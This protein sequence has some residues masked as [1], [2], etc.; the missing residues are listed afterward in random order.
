MWQKRCCCAFFSEWSLEGLF[1]FFFLEADKGGGKKLFEF[2]R[3][4]NRRTKPEALQLPRPYWRARDGEHPGK[5]WALLP[6]PHGKAG[7]A[8][9]AKCLP[10]PAPRRAAGTS[11]PRILPGCWQPEPPAASPGS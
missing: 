7:T 11:I 2:L 9:S 8:L 3:G 10:R 4:E 1:F 6:A 5:G